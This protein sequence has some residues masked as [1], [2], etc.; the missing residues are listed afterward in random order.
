MDLQIDQ[1]SHVPVHVQ[2]EA[3]IKHLILAGRFEVGSR[4][5]SI[6]A[7]AGYL[8]INRNTVARV[9]ADLEREGY[10][11]SRR[12]SGIYV[13]EPRVD[14]ENLERREVLEWVMDLA[15]ARGVPVEDL[16]YALLA[17]AGAEPREK[18]RI[19]F[20]ECT[21]AELDQFS[22]ELERQLPVEVERVLLEDLPSKVAEEEE[23]PWRMAVTT[24]F[25][26][27]E[28]QEVMNPRGV[29]TVALLAEA[30]LESLR[31]L[32]ELPAGTPVGVVGWGRTCMENLSRSI[33]GAGLDHLRFVQ[34]YLDEDSPDDTWISLEEV[35]AVVCATI[36]AKKLRELG[37][38]EGLEIIEEDRTLDKGGIEMLGRMLR[39]LPGT[40]RK[41]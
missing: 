41:K 10:V 6:R 28:V 11:E 20:I 21:R 8:R 16:A 17:R 32:T 24:F 34:I 31:R 1:K 22:A 26:V 13:L 38:P 25:H 3:Q 12:G 7:L 19:L 9:M 15:A 27:H 4:L 2:L 39:A 35:R 36:T 14:A 5:P 37:I 40:G 33:E 30:N 18:S 29:E 23:P